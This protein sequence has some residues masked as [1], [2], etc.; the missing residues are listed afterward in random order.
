M[1]T[2]MINPFAISVTRSLRTR[3]IVMAGADLVFVSLRKMTT[4]IR[5][6]YAPTGD[7]NPVKCP[8]H[9]LSRD[10]VMRRNHH[11]RLAAEISR[12]H[13]LGNGIRNALPCGGNARRIT[14]RADLRTEAAA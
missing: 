2:K 7:A 10:G 13:L 14:R 4:F 12:S 1:T 11:K 5:R 6:A 8:P 9:T 3:H